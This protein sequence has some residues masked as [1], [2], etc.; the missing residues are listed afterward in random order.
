VKIRKHGV[1]VPDKVEQQMTPMIDVVF[2]LLSFFMFTLRISELEGNFNIKMP[3]PSSVQQQ[4]LD[5]NVPPVR[6]RLIANQD[7]T[8]KSIIYQDR[9][10]RD[11][12]ALRSQIVA[13]VGGDSGLRDNAE[14]EIDA[15]YNLHYRYTIDAVTHV[16]GYIADDG[17]STVRLIE[18]IRF[19]QPKQPGQK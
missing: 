7:G 14:V 16:S 19:A 2:Q 11:F 5:V 18:K 8:L 17:Q 12:A 10:M 15:D 1:G 4:Q 3:A 9:P 6:V 13:H